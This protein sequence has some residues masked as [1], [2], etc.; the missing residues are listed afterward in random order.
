MLLG[1]IPSSRTIP[2]LTFDELVIK[3][4]STNLNITREINELIQCEKEILHLIIY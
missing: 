2:I 4:L 1:S 3:K